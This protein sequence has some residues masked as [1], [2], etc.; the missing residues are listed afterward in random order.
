MMESRG[1]LL[2]KILLS[3][4]L[5]GASA[6]QNTPS[7]GF[8]SPD[9]ITDIGGT[10]EL[11]CRIQNENPEMK[12][13][14]M[15]MRLENGKNPSPLPISSGDSLLLSSD[16]RFKLDVD[17]DE[18]SYTITIKDIR[19]AD[20]GKYQC[21][22]LITSDG[23]ITEDVE[24]KIK[25]QPVIT[26]NSLS[27]T[28]D[29]QEGETVELG[30]EATGFPIPKITWTRQDGS[31]LPNGKASFVSS[32]MI[33]QKV[34]R[35]DRGIYVCTADNG[36]GKAQNRKTHLNIEFSPKIKVPSPRIP[37]ALYHEALLSCEIKASPSPVM[38]WKKNNKTI[39]NDANHQ[40]SH[41]ALA[42]EMTVT[43]LKVQI[44]SKK[45]FG[46]YTCAAN[47]RHGRDAQDMELYESKLPIMTPVDLSNG[48]NYLPLPLN[49]ALIC[50]I[51]I[52]LNF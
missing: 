2:I 3:L 1:K 18:S 36:V 42:D 39:D 31:L 10:A 12:Y 19:K 40:I 45:E 23:S 16:R 27:P 52:L 17:E 11:T 46:L 43:K 28:K 34:R 29:A 25:L 50:L 47:N 35:E 49:I 48:L 37:Q 38:Y 7:I 15:W 51:P 41:F 30:C 8:I 44:N 26:K 13:P 4:V 24:L 9:V 22:V 6:G 5:A 14:V 32:R 20:A 33:I 21:Q